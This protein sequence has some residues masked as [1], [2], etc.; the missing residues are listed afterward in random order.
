MFGRGRA[1]LSSFDK[2]RMKGAVFGA[3]GLYGGCTASGYGYAILH[4]AVGV[5]LPP[6]GVAG[7]GD[8][9]FSLHFPPFWDGA[10]R[11]MGLGLV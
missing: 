1:P 8:F 4:L 5:V 10:G 11:G 6:D 2:L 7:G 9:W 3:F